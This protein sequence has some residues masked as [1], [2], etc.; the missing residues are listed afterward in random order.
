[1]SNKKVLCSTSQFQQLL[2]FMSQEYKLI[3]PTVRDGA[4]V[5]DELQSAADLPIGW[6]DEQDPGFYRLKRRPDNAYFGYNLGQ[7]SWKRFLFP[8]RE[9]LYS[10]Q[11][12]DSL[13]FSRGLDP[14]I[15]KMAFIGVRACEIQAMLVQDKVF[16]NARDVYE[17]YQK[18]RE[19]IFI[20]A[21]QCTT[22][23][24]TCFCSSMKSGP[25]VK[26]GF[27]LCLTEVIERQ[28]HYFVIEIGTSKGGSLC[29]KIAFAE[30][31]DKTCQKAS[32][33]IEKNKCAM[34][35][36]VDNDHI[37]QMLMN[38]WNCKRWNHVASRCINCANCTMVCPTCFCS[39]ITCTVSIDGL[40]ADRW[41]SW[42]SCFN[43]SHSYIHDGPVRKS[44]LSRYRQWLTHKF[45]T[46]W[47][48]FG[49]SGCVGCGR[50]ITWCPVGID[51]TEEL[52]ELQIEMEKK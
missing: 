14:A 42:D 48:Q 3:G 8:P 34:M 6:M 16:Q 36:H 18:R 10:I 17:Q 5:Y 29:Q 35:R 38:S 22:S 24:H 49:L 46:W 20:L 12:K 23:A 19:N 33:L 37:H 2:T 50:C 45:G 32:L 7:H 44:D 13:T 15:E 25:E 39:E 4:I 41:Q 26:G 27:D 31:D 28:N 21:V 1:M 11:K 51:V 30:A 9:K 40:H 43:L 52:R 47:D